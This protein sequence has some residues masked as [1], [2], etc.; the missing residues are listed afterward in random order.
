MLLYAKTEEEIQ[1]DQKYK[2]SGNRISVR[3]LDLNLD[4]SEIRKQ[5][6]DIVEEYFEEAV[7]LAKQHGVCALCRK[8]ADLE[9]SHIV[10]K[11]VVREL[12]KTSV[13]QLR[14]TE[15]QNGTVPGQ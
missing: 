9:L 2:M 8:E 12:K 15:N 1:P 4:F 10:P 11:M 3:T 5:L 7:Q 13:G 14:S 6:D